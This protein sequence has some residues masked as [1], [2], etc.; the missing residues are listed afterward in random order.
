MQT[1]LSQ[2][3]ESFCFCSRGT[4]GLS[5]PLPVGQAGSASFLSVRE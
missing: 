2:E 1:D 4:D 5:R 3:E